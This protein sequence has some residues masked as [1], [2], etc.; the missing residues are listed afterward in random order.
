ME[1]AE[2][3]H[4]LTVEEVLQ[5]E[6]MPELQWVQLEPLEVLQEELQLLEVGE[7]LHK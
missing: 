2:E 6:L 5:G 7:L 1:V 3:H 4:S